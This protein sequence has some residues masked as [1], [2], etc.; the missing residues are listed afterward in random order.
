M[1]RQMKVE[2]Q[3][4]KGI[5]HSRQIDT[6]QKQQYVILDEQ[7]LLYEWPF[8]PSHLSRVL[9]ENQIHPT[10]PAQRLCF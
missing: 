6:Y 4:W 5:T 1:R 10:N 2:K 9:A 3:T 8:Q 7:D